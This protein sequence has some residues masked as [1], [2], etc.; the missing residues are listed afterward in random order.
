[1]T[2][3]FFAGVGHAAFCCI[4]GPMLAVRAKVRGY[5]DTISAQ[6]WF[7]WPFVLISMAPLFLGCFAV[8]YD[9]QIENPVW[10]LVGIAM[11]FII[12]VPS[13]LLLFWLM[14]RRK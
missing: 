6:E 12:A 1:M 8:V 13:S 9:W 10:R 4:E 11:C 5:F 7:W 3:G 2:I 14:S